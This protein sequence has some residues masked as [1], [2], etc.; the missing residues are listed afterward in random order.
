MSKPNANIS[1]PTEWHIHIQ[2]SAYS[3]A[4]SKL[5]WKRI[6]LHFRCKEE[7]RPL[8]NGIACFKLILNNK[9]KSYKLKTDHCHCG[10]INENITSQGM[11]K[12]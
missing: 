12:L 10:R 7:S 2:P 11:N 8:R 6:C 9:K 3:L 4:S 5:R 1:L